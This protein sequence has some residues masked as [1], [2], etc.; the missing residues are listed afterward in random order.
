MV[1]EWYLI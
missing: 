1:V